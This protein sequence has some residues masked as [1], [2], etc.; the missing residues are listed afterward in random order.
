MKIIRC[1]QKLIK[2]LKVE[3]EENIWAKSWLESWHANVFT[4]RREKCVL[5]TNDATLY[6]LLICGLKKE[7]FLHFNHMVNQYFFK[8]MLADG[9]SQPLLEK[10]LSTDDDIVF[11]KS[12]NKS[13]M[14]SMNNYKITIEHFMY[15]YE[16][17]Y[18]GASQ[19]QHSINRMPMKTI[20]FQFP[21]DAFIEKL[22]ND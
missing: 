18:E 2:E 3:P 6:S 21:I 20:G 1:T 7:N 12:A 14:A 10:A 17:P 4:V 22:Q 15:D 5:I 16:D 13:T 9:L 11:T 19:A 8:L